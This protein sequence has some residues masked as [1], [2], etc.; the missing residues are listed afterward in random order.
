M[1]TP[2]LSGL[3]GLL[4]VTLSAELR[5]APQGAI[6]RVSLSY[7]GSEPNLNCWRPDVSDDGRFVTF[8][9]GATDLVPIDSNGQWDVFVRDMQLGLT[10]RVSVSS[11]GAEA[12]GHSELARMSRD[13]RFV[14]FN[15]GASNLVSGDSNGVADIFVHDRLTAATERVSVDSN[16]LQA[17]GASGLSDVSSTGRYVVFASAAA[18]LVAGDTNQHIDIFVRDR[19]AGTTV[20]ASL[21]SG[22]GEPS[23]ESLDASISADGRF[24]VFSSTSNDLVAGDTNGSEDVFV[25]DMQLG[26]TSRVSVSTAGGEGNAASF[27]GTISNDGRLIAFTSIASNLVAGDTNDTRDVFVHDRST[28]QTRRVSVGSTGAQGNGQSFAAR[29]SGHGGFVAFL[30]D[31]STLVSGDTNG[32]RDG[33]VHEL[34]AG[35]TTRFTVGGAGQQGNGEAGLEVWSSISSDGRWVSFASAASNLVAGDTN[36]WA[37]AF[38][39][40]RAWFEPWSYCTG[41]TTTNACTA[42]VSASALPSVSGANACMLSVTNVEGQKSGLIFYSV[43]GALIQPWSAT[44]TS[45]LCVKTPTQRSPTQN[46]GGTAGACDGGFAL[47]WNAFQAAN[48][49]A[50][51]NPW[52]AGDKLFAQAWFRD[53]PAS[54]S[55]NLSNAIELTYQP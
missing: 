21:R 42:Q 8:I 19:L 20:R 53:P 11:S 34:G 14:A 16:G 43:A 17:N 45:L 1:N 48:P 49:G 28:G 5:A 13:G 3:A 24:V 35:L 4:F 40:D 54:K 9:S 47:D 30:S 22:G 38:T 37:D 51:G 52:S 55:T 26:T 10:T 32:V 2:R 18:N 50:L 29:I 25:R 41:G 27:R 7:Q 39:L 23:G 15:S 44:S 12:N 6:S 33:F 46:S 36:G 31:A